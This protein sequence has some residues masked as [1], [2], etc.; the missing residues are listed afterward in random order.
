MISYDL[1][2]RNKEATSKHALLRGYTLPSYYQEH[3]LENLQKEIMQEL[4]AQYFKEGNGVSLAEGTIIYFKVLMLIGKFSLAIKELN[5][6]G[7]FIIES[8]HFAIAL[9]ELGL[10]KTR[11]K[12]LSLVE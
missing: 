7:E 1:K 6:L 2:G 5:E 11:F 10:L 9:K 8:T 12:L 4:G 3:T